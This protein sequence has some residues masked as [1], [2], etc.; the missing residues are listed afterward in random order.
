MIKVMK[1]REGISFNLIL[2]VTKQQSNDKLI[3]GKRYI[4][5]ANDKF[6]REVKK[7]ATKTK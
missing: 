5:D 6:T 1:N 2:L 3:K 7:F 4:H